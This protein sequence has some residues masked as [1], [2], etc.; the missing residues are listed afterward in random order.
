MLHHTPRNRP[1]PPHDLGEDAAAAAASPPDVSVRA[2][3]WVDQCLWAAAAVV[4]GSAA[5][6]GSSIV[7]PKSGGGLLGA[8][9]VGGPDAHPELAEALFRLMGEWV[10]E[11]P[12]PSLRYFTFLYLEK[13]MLV[14][15][16]VC[17][18]VQPDRSCSR[19]PTVASQ[20]VGR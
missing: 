8:T 6:S 2:S 16:S 7:S 11:L 12:V 5:G 9:P 17:V 20:Y 1:S 13:L 10:K 18:C 15:N 19:E 4:G 14:A 3:E